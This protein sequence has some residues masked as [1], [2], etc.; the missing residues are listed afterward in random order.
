M[1]QPGFSIKVWYHDGWYAK[2]VGFDEE[3]EGEIQPEPTDDPVQ[4]LVDLASEMDDR[5]KDAG[6]TEIFRLP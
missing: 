1:K 3:G 4:L 2:T 5:I 6:R